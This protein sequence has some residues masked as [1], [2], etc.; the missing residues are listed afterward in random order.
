MIQE[1]DERDEEERK[2][3]I[4]HH[5]LPSKAVENTSNPM[6]VRQMP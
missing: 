5:H 1:I 4:D 3:R 6:M 2:T